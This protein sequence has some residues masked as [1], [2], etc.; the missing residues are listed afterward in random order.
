VT[1]IT[2]ALRTWF[3][4][5]SARIDTTDLVAG[6][7]IL[8][9]LA[10]GLLAWPSLPAEMAVHFSGGEADT[11]MP[12]S[13]A[14]W[15]VPAIGLAAVA[16][17]RRE[18]GADLMRLVRLGFV[19]WVVGGAHLYVVAWNLGYRVSSLVILVP[20]LVGAALLVAAEQTG[21]GS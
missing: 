18:P 11:Y 10:V 12:R 21:F 8:A 2:N 14:V 9:S 5:G 7:P 3:T 13:V 15:L 1:R 17:V 16:V 20:V 19:G 4:V 6:V